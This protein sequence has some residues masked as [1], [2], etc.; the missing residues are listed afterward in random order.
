MRMP[1]VNLLIRSKMLKRGLLL[2]EGP[3]GSI[4]VDIDPTTRR[5]RQGNL[6][7]GKYRVRASSAQYGRGNASLTV[8]ERDVVRST[9]T[10]DGTPATGRTSLS[11]HVQGA[12][13]DALQV[14]ITDKVTGRQV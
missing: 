10:L 7:A 9:I 5:F 11:L 3:S 2:L 12:T 14:R 13:S 6:L 1:M 8:R 4:Q